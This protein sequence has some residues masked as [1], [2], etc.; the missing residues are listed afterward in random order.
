MN[1]I[2]AFFVNAYAKAPGTKK[3]MKFQISTFNTFV[4]FNLTKI[5]FAIMIAG[6]TSTA[7]G[8]VQDA[9]PNAA[10]PISNVS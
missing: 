9:A 3:C 6:I 2:T 1:P 8:V 4:T 5:K 10:N 7:N